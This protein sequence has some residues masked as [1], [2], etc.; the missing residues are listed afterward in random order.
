MAAPKKQIDPRQKERLSTV[1]QEK[2]IS[3]AALAKLLFVSRQTV[4][5]YIN[6]KV[7]LP[8]EAAKAIQDAYGY[9]KAWLLCEDD[10][11]TWYEVRLDDLDRQDRRFKSDMALFVEALESMGMTVEICPENDALLE[12]W[13]RFSLSHKL[14]MSDYLIKKDE[15]LVAIITSKQME[16]LHTELTHYARYLMERAIEEGGADDGE[17]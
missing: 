1:L 13:D 10:R 3:K 17:Q 7:Q 4:Y 15:E 5:D 16:N 8:K 9:N 2:G 11:K 12:V 14:P 6:C